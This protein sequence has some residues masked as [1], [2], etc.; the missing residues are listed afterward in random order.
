MS[1]G[2]PEVPDEQVFVPLQ[3]VGDIRPLTVLIADLLKRDYAIPPGGFNYSKTANGQD[4]NAR[5]PAC[6]AL[7][8]GLTT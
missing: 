6:S 4:F 5:C 1:L 7:V 3:Q 8:G 2:D